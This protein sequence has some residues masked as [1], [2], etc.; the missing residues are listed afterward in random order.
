MAAI[1]WKSFSTLSSYH[2][3]VVEMRSE[4]EIVQG[5]LNP[6]GEGYLDPMPEMTSDRVSAITRLQQLAGVE[7]TTGEIE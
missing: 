3:H 1:A 2:D 7:P 5:K 6:L 4:I